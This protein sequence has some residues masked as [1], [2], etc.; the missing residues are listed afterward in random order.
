MIQKVEIPKYI[1][2]I[3]LSEARI[4]K[5]YELG[6]K[7]PKSEKFNDKTKYEYKEVPGYGKR[8]FLVDL[9]TG[10]RVVANPRAAGT[11]R[12][13]TINGQKIY[14]GEVSKHIRN[15]VLSEIK[16]SFI[17][18]IEKL[19]EIKNFP[20][21]IEMEI[22]DVIREPNSKSLWDLDNRAWPY[23]KAFQDCLTGNKDKQ[24]KKRNKVVLKDDNVLYITQPPVP[25]FIP[26]E[27]E[28]DRKLVFIIKEETDQRILS[29][30][31]YIKELNNLKI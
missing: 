14:N 15:K 3:K 27:K 7:H 17:P 31:E 4:K 16:T 5:Y 1:R 2:E 26:V 13:L 25:K 23:I 28:D 19:N 18:Y 10:E 11:P 22:H 6:K 21:C 9:K 12:V 24:G 30:T 20:I 8:K 29:N